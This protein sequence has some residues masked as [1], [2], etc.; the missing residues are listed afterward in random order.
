MEKAR[1]LNTWDGFM[2]PMPFSRAY[3]RV[4]RKILVPADADYA[5]LAEAH[6]EMQE[7]LERITAYAES[8]FSSSR[9]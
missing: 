4:A 6:V 7:A 2:I 3:V 1:V 8:Q 5:R 9:V